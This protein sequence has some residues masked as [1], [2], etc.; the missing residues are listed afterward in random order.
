MK[1]PAWDETRASVVRRLQAIIGKAVP[2]TETSEIAE[3]AITLALSAVRNETG[4]ALFFRNVWRNSRHVLRRRRRRQRLV[5]DALDETTS[6][7]RR[8]IAG[9]LPGTEIVLTPESE[10]VAA[11]LEERIRTEVSR[12]NETAVGCLD[13]L[14]LGETVDQTAT[15]LQTTPQQVRSIRS[16]IRQIARVIATGSRA[17]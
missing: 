7:G 16:S 4:P 5:I 10:A 1:R 11:D 17:A 9:G 14:L 15:R 3:H 12:L 8:V 6:L 2:G 13:G